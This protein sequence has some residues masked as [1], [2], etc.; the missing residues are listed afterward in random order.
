M[1]IN[2]LSKKIHGKKNNSF[3]DKEINTFK[4]LRKNVSALT[5]HF[6]AKGNKM[7]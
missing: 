5:H 6:Y 3:S 4:G 2:A 1:N 7:I